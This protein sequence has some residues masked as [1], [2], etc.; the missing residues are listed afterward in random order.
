MGLCFVYAVKG[1]GDVIDNASY[2]AGGIGRDGVE[3]DR[4]V[5]MLPFDWLIS[6]ISR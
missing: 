1:F 4:E 3:W 5:M 2:R 6:T